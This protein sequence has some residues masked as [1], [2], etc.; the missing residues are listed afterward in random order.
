MNRIYILLIPLLV[1]S[2]CAMPVSASYGG[3]YDY[4]QSGFAQ[5]ENETGNETT[6]ETQTEIQSEEVPEEVE[7]QLAPYADIVSYDFDKDNTSVEITL[8]T[9]YNV[10]ITITDAKIP[11]NEGIG[12]INQEEIMIDGVETVTFDVTKVGNKMG[13][14]I[15]AGDGLYGI[16]VTDGWSIDAQYSAEEMAIIVIMSSAVGITLVL[17]LA[18]RRKLKF[19]EEV[20]KIL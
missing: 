9:D 18:Y 6:N 15:T 2:M 12:N 8:R 10:P 20:E 16:I 11:P 17:G 7:Q 14:T 1:V 19:S 4:A 5:V 3:N 13:F